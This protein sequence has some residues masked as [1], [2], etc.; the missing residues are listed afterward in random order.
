MRPTRNSISPISIGGSSR[1]VCS[2][3]S[4][5][6]KTPN[7][8]TTEGTELHRG[9]PQRT[10]W[11]L[12]SLSP[13]LPFLRGFPLCTSVS[14]VV[15]GLTFAPLHFEVYLCGEGV[16]FYPTDRHAN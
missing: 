8:F 4:W 3:R 2:S 5:G 13:L 6:C 7:T 1:C 9:K 11:R 12:R 14:S 10:F 15:K 16:G